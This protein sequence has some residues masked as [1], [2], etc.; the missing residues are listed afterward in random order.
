MY[1]VVGSMRVVC[2][3]MIGY[4]CYFIVVVVGG[5]VVVF[6]WLLIIGLCDDGR[7]LVCYCLFLLSF[8]Y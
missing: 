5:V 7:G 4:G 2:S 6:G 1:V 8:V 3:W